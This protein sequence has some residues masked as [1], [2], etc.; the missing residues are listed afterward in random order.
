MLYFLIPT[1]PENLLSLKTL[2]DYIYLKLMIRSEQQRY[3]SGSNN[4]INIFQT[5]ACFLYYEP[6]KDVEKMLDKYIDQ[7]TSDQ[8]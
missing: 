1:P 4:N 7:S 2:K 6:S 5:H 8:Q 3:M